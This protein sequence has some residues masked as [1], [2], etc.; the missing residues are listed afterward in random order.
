MRLCLSALLLSLLVLGAAP[1][2]VTS[3]GEP[4]FDIPNGRFFTQTGGGGGRG[5]AVTDESGVPFWS[6]LRRLGGIQAVGY[7]ASQRF[8]WDGF[9]VQVF[10]RVVFQWRPEAGQAYFINVFDRLHDL[11]LDPWLLQTRQTPPPRA[12]DDA[13]KTWEQVQ[14]NH[15]AVMDAFPA[16]RASYFGVVGDPIQANGLPVSDV[17]DMGNHFAL[18]SQRVVFQEWKEDVPWAQR[19]TVTIA[20]G[21]DI[22]K[23]AGILPDPAALQSTLPGGPQPRPTGTL[24]GRVLD[25]ENVVPRAQVE[26]LDLP[27]LSARAGNDGRYQLPNVPFG[28][29]RIYMRNEA[30]TASDWR[31]VELN[32]PALTFDVQVRTIA[33]AT[34]PKSIRGR[35]V[36]ADG[37]MVSGATV[38]RLNDPSRTSSRGDGRFQLVYD[39]QNN[40]LR[41]PNVVSQVTLIAVRGDRWGLLDVDPFATPA[42]EPVIRLDRLAP[43]PTPPVL[44]YD[45]LDR[46]PQATWQDA[47]QTAAGAVPSDPVTVPFGATDALPGPR[48]FARYLTGPLLEDDSRPDRALQMRPRRVDRGLILG[49]YSDPIA[50]QPN[51]FFVAEFGFLKGRQGSVVLDVLFVPGSPADPIASARTITCQIG[52]RRE[53]RHQQAEG[54]LLVLASLDGLGVQG[55]TGRLM[56]RVD[57]AVSAGGNPSNESSDLD[58]VVWT[59][60][61]IVRAR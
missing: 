31:Q 24:S 32:A 26:L 52:C 22:A 48:G 43:A 60:A 54:R 36:A 39:F 3:Q 11:G 27:A 35:V 55:Q 58:D 5:F 12:F 37:T 51:D 41:A 53:Y 17:V 4:D 21:G 28:Q 9:T 59:Q 50:V 15:L 34:N 44:V 2:V 40:Y 6:E 57:A 7:P 14:Q 56:L 29:H 45:L 33:P 38:W 13:G 49:L 10:Q 46:A 47:L 61:Q 1:G 23:E 8:Q 18:R 16:I 42:Q 20:L 25:G 30:G 19:G